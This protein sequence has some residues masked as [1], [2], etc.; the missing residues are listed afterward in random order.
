[1]RHQKI[2]YFCFSDNQSSGGN[3][4]I[5][6]HTE[7]LNNNGYEAYVLHTTVNFKI[8]WFPH[9]A[10][11]IYIDAFEQLFDKQTDFIVLPEDLGYDILSFPGNKIIF[12]QNMYYGF[13]I[14]GKQKPQTYPYLHSDIKGA[15]VVS[16]HNKN[17]LKFAY[18]QL[19]VFRV[20]CGVDLSKFSYQSLK[21][22]K[23]KIACN[24]AKRPLDIAAVYHIL[25]SR[26]EQGL[27]NL[28]EYEWIFIEDK[29]E[30][31]VAQ[32]LQESLIFIFLS[33]EEGFPLMPLEAMACGCLVFAYNT[34]PITEYVHPTFLF[35]PGDFLSIT[36]TIE[37]ITQSF[38]A[39]AENWETISEMGR[40]TALQYSLELEQKSVVKAWQEI[41]HNNSTD[42]SLHS[43]QTKQIF[44]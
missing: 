36:E 37:S 20:F 24:P 40:D 35:D 28:D 8:T 6:K 33:K 23:K 14:F 9:N 21:N 29:T 30:L 34:A 12:N 7:I 18:P 5:Y 44:T 43:K 31:E 39:A 3:K 15:L 25:Q 32:I 16:E 2:F 19:D 4:E 38:P 26:A 13:H 1:M 27:N 42:C 11:I 41:L 10:R 22:K 17:Y